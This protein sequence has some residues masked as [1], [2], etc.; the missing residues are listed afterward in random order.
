M[1]SSNC[2][3]HTAYPHLVSL[4]IDSDLASIFLGKFRKARKKHGCP[5]QRLTVLV[6]DSVP[7]NSP[8][9]TQ[10]SGSAHSGDGG[11]SLANAVRPLNQEGRLEEQDG[12]SE[13]ELDSHVE[14]QL[15]SHE[16][17]NKYVPKVV[18]EY[19]KPLSE[20]LISSNWPTD[21]FMRYH[22]IPGQA[23]A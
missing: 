18:L 1:T 12:S 7:R 13:D 11:L 15:R 6:C 20:D 3:V 17:F 21:V 2:F 8:A 9:A 19:N 5:V 22:G 4:G 10:T 23:T 16:L 14:L